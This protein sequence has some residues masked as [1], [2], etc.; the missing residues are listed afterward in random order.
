[1][2]WYNFLAYHM[3]GA[4]MHDVSCTDF[5]FLYPCIQ[6]NSFFLGG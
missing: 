5:Y 2:Y 3:A 4:N 6:E 1:M